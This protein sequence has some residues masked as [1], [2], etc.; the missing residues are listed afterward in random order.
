MAGKQREVETGVGEQRDDGRRIA[1]GAREVEPPAGP[2][3]TATVRA[4]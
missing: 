1:A 2:S 4:T 3:G